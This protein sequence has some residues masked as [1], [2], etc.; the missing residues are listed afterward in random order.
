MKI[1]SPDR[2]VIAAATGGDLDA[3]DRLLR[4][5]QPGI[6]NLAVRMLGNREDAADA[7]QEI[8]LRVV[9]HLSGFRGESA[10][11]TW[12]FRV[13]R[14]HL[15]DAVTRTKEAP[16]WSLDA[17]REQLARGLAFDGGER[18]SLTPEDKLEA[19]Q[20]AIRC[21]QSL[22]MTLDRA[23]RLAYLLDLVFGLTSEEAADVLQISAAA[24]RKRLSRARSAIETFAASTCGLVDERAPCRCDRQLPALRHVDAQTAR[25]VGALRL[26]HPVEWAAAERQFDAIV[27][28]S[29]RAAVFRAHPD[30]Q[31]PDAMI[32][33]IRAVLAGHG[34]EPH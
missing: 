23:Q 1:G 9:T 17:M 28:M 22:L 27:R 5:V 30:Y 8:L 11:P 12:V 21:T 13:A 16:H 7:T 19:R 15:L 25:P 24:Y 6:F 14:N 3:I 4:T 20:V 10:F 32:G 2:A 33:A 31:A 34:G 29:D 18:V 26:V